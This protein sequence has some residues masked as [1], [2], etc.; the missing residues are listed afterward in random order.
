MHEAVDCKV[1]DVNGD[2]AIACPSTFRARFQTHSNFCQ[3]IKKFCDEA[4][5]TV[6]LKP[7][8]HTVLVD[9]YSS[10]ESRNLFQRNPS[11]LTREKTAALFELMTQLQNPLTSEDLKLELIAASEILIREIPI[12]ATGLRLDVLAVPNSMATVPPF[13]WMS[14]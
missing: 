9:E 10:A 6:Q 7:L 1:L 12:D 11:A 3:I 14:R 8:T 5:L 4:E 13:S 2:H